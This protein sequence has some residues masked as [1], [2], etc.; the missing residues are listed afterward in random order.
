MPSPFTAASLWFLWYVSHIM[1]K[2]LVVLAVTLV[3]VGLCGNAQTHKTEQAQGNQQPSSPVSDAQVKQNE[4]PAAQPKS[5][6][7]IQAD[8]R[9]IDA[10]AKDRYDKATFWINFVFTIMVISGVGV[11]IC[12]LIYLRKQADEMRLQRKVMVRSLRAMREQGERENK[13]I[14]LQYRP[15]VIV[16]NAKAIGLGIESG[17]P[18]VC[19][20]EFLL[21]NTGGSP[22]HI[23]E[24]SIFLLS[25]VAGGIDNIQFIDSPKWRFGEGEL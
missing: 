14:V 16:R 24:G 5:E 3:L 21:V 25:Y 9:V 2:R 20:L 11:G 22:A 18:G 7:H 10:P 1:L 17:S 19:K 12:T 4:S 6:T 15:R 8:V 13:T 23:I